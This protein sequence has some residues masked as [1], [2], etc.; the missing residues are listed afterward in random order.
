[1]DQTA[2]IL[3]F[4]AAEPEGTRNPWVTRYRQ[5]KLVLKDGQT[6]DA[7]TRV[8]TDFADWLPEQ[9]GSHKPFQPGDITANAVKTYFAGKKRDRR[10]STKAE[11]LLID[12]G[13][14]SV[15]D[16]ELRYG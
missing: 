16:L 15:Q 13:Q 12:A 6:I 7:Y 8:L 3:H 9:A 1:M 5:E 10:R 11:Q 2:H 14:L 4:P